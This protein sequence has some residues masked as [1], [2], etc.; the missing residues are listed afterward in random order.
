MKPFGGESKKFR[1]VPRSATDTTP[2]DP[3]IAEALRKAGRDPS[4]FT[5]V[6][7]EEREAESFQGLFSSG[8]RVEH[9]FVFST[10]N[11]ALSAIERLVD[12]ETAA[13]ITKDKAGWL[14][15]FDAP[16]QAGV[17]GTAQ[18]ERFVSVTAPFGGEDRGFA[19]LTMNVNRIKK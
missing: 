3:K 18:H 2:L 8:S 12:N 9:T 11:G 5:V 13:R 10:L 14:V 7:F 16:D 15:V 1:V 6:P 4:K 19:R 17:A